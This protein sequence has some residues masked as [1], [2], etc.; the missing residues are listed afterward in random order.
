MTSALPL[1]VAFVEKRAV[2]PEVTVAALTI[3]PSAG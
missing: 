2:A 1:P 3:E